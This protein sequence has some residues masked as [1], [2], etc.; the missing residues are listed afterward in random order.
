MIYGHSKPRDSR[1]EIVESDICLDIVFIKMQK[2][3]H[4]KTEINQNN[5]FGSLLH[6]SQRSLLSFPQ[7]PNTHNHLKNF[8]YYV[9]LL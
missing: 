9:R 5:K 1:G 3:I 6:N 7:N 2:F 8:V 4:K